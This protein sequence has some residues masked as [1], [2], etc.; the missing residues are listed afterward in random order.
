MEMFQLPYSSLFGWWVTTI[1]W[2][3]AFLVVVS[4][5]LYWKRVRKAPTAARRGRLGRIAEDLVFVWVLLGLLIFYIV[6]VSAGS[7]LL[8]AAGNILVEVL[9]LVYVLREKTRKGI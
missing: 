8:F 3:I 1:S 6:S 7:V 2:S 9:L 5:Y 4:F